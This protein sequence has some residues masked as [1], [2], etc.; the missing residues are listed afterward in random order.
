MVIDN[1]KIH[2]Y[3]GIKDLFTFEFLYSKLHQKVK[4]MRHWPGPSKYIVNIMQ[5]SQRGKKPGVKRSL[6][7]KDEFF[8][9]L[10][11]IHTGSSCELIGD[12][13]GVT[14][15]CVS[16]ICTSSFKFLA[17]ELSHLIYSPSQVL[18]SYHCLGGS[19]VICSRM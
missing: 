19:K 14:K 17:A 11:R 16:G 9:T 13:F 18:Q 10:M 12:M 1:L 5:K 15:S 8:I 2:F 3:T 4:L 7:L 6:D